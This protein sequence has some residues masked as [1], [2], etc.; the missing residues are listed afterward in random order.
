MPARMMPA[1]TR[2]VAAFVSLT[3]PTPSRTVAANWLGRYTA[4]ELA[5][6][7]TLEVIDGSPRLGRQGSRR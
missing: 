5:V 3:P 4:L 1:H 2:N 7:R 6:R